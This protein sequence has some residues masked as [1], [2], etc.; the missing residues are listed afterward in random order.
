MAVSLPQTGVLTSLPSFHKP[1]KLRTRGV[2]EAEFVFESYTLLIF[3]YALK[4]LQFIRLKPLSFRFCKINTG[5]FKMLCEDVWSK[6][7]L[8]RT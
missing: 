5:Q 3:S 7:L 6:A 1:R 2:A 4:Y 8:F